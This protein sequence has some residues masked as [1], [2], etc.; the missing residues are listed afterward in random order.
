[1][2]TKLFLAALTIP[3]IF[4][5]CSQDEFVNNDTAKEVVGTPL[6]ENLVFSVNKGTDVDTRLS[7]SG[8]QAD[9]IVGMAWM[10]DDVNNE[11]SP[12]IELGDKAYAN[13]PLYYTSGAAFQSKTMMYV[14]SYIAYYPY[15]EDLKS[16]AE[17]TFDVAAEQTYKDADDFFGKLVFASDS[18]GLV[19][20]T[21]GNG[22]TPTI[23]LKQLSNRLALDLQFKNKNAQMTDPITVKSVTIKGNSSEGSKP[24]ATSVKA[25]GDKWIPSNTKDDS[26]TKALKDLTVSAEYLTVVSDATSN[27]LKATPETAVALA[28]ATKDGSLSNSQIFFNILP[29]VSTDNVSGATIVVETNYGSVEIVAEDILEKDNGKAT[30]TTEKGLDDLLKAYTLGVGKSK[31]LRV[32]VDMDNA[33]LGSPISCKNVEEIES[34]ISLWSKVQSSSP[35]TINIIKTAD[36]DQKIVLTDLDLSTL[37]ASITGELT[38]NA[39]AV[40]VEFAGTTNLGD[41]T[42]DGNQKYTFA[43]TTTI[44]GKVEIQT[45]TSVD[46]AND[47]IVTIDG[48]KVTY[49]VDGATLA[50][51]AKTGTKAGAVLNLINAGEFNKELSGTDATVTVGEGATINVGNLESSGYICSK[52]G[53]SGNNLGT[54][55]YYNGL[56]LNFD[57]GVTG[58]IAAIVSNAIAFEAAVTNNVVDI[59]VKGGTINFGAFTLSKENLNV[60]LDQGGTLNLGKKQIKFATLTIAADA[61]ISGT[62]GCKLTTTGLLSISKTTTLTV[63]ENVEVNAEQ[64]SLPSEATLSNAGVFKYISATLVG[65][66]VSGEGETK[67]VDS[68]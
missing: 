55:N 66:T 40:P 33:E 64:L 24:F 12:S 59:T 17:L 65:G 6:G 10:T 19:A 27:S 13:H 14:G 28:E 23:T 51:T 63:N 5:A 2:K 26:D 4:A 9:D 57:N 42:L 45:T 16:I 50:L 41:L 68:F 31:M 11:S 20:G 36:A 35:L 39:E 25:V 22:T 47:A 44:T 49:D 56:Q 30:Y 67:K 62:E 52:E 60:T 37:P 53:S 29:C 34:A 38:L 46:I 8:W 43:G 61:A 58:K 21:A 15:N 18:V 3:A 7:Q 48:G 54:I 1:M 32:L